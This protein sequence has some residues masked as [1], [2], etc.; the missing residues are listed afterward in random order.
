M[1]I[2]EILYFFVFCIFFTS[3]KNQNS[4]SENGNQSA[5]TT[6]KVQVVEVVHPV[7]RSFTGK[8]L[9]SGTVH[10]NQSVVLY[11]M[12]SGVVSRIS[13]DIGDKVYKGESIASLS[14]P[15]IGKSV[16]KAIA[17]LAISR[18]KIKTANADLEAVKSR[19]EGLQSISNRLS[20]IYSRTPQLTTI[21]SVETAKADAKESDAIVSSR[22]AYITGLYEEVKSME[23]NLSTAQKQLSFLSIS[24]PFSGII[25]KR[26]VDKGAM[27]QNGLNQINPQA[28]V[29]IQ[30]I[31]PVR[32][33]LEVPE[34]DAVSIIKGMDVEV[35]FPELSSKVY[36]T[37][38][39]RTSGVLDPMSKTMQV[40]IDINN[41][42]GKIISGMYAKAFLQ[43]ESRENI[44]SLP[45]ISKVKY[46]NEDYVMVVENDRVV[47]MPIKIGLSDE[48]FYEVINAEITKDSKVIVSG[49]NLV[50]PGQIV[51][52][53]IK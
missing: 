30:Q 14:N 6:T 41:T 25:S 42:S 26:F 15:L 18:A 12:Q 43:L 45:A 48:H 4:K 33:V 50:T 51:N 9:I 16:S 22:Q 31:N 29:E 44:L 40:E 38:I 24:A 34:S 35:T 11:A 20:E 28:I 37:K 52:A 32:L 7:Q 46:K 17:D 23:V 13:K 10:P 8:V 21:S 19:A 39:S 53:T 47:R 2:I 1:S 3:C 5:E 49:K 27:V 36:S